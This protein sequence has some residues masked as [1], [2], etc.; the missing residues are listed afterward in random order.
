MPNKAKTYIALVMLSGAA[1]LG[2]AA[3]TWPSG[4]LQQFVIYL[5]L[6]ALAST[7]KVRI[8]GLEGTM[9]PNFLFLLLAMVACR[10]SEV[11]VI[12]LVAAL[13]QSL[14][15]ARRARLVQVSFSAATL[16]VSSAVAF[17]LAHLSV[18]GNAGESSV[19][20]VLL[21]G[22]L[23]FPLNSAMVSV[24]I[25]LV[26]G[27][28][29]KHVMLRCY[30]WVFRHFMGGIIFAALISG[31]YSAS[32]AWHGAL[33]LLPAVVLA[34]LYYANRAAKAYREQVPVAAD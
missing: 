3:A 20:F 8:P 32:T 1:V 15:R 4:G 25:G 17:K 31:A 27:Q 23:Y 19:P 10:F 6:A 30:E 7:L 9:S 11:V 26:E 5:S 21:A 33:V 34:Y 22:S 18:A 28:Q 24:V 29:L 12:S 14:W 2:L 16:M 13:V